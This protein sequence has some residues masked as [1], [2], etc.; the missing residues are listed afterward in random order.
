MHQTIPALQKPTATLL[1]D[2]DEL[3]INNIKKLLANNHS[4]NNAHVVSPQA[5]LSACDMHL[6]NLNTCGQFEPL[7]TSE[8]INKKTTVIPVSII[9]IDDCMLPHNGLEI[10]RQIKSPFVQKI[11][12]S[13]FFSNEQAIDALNQKVINYYLCKMDIQFV[14]KLAQAIEEAQRQFFFQLSSIIPDF[15]DEDNPLLEPKI[16]ELFQKIKNEYG[17][18]HY[19]A[20]PDLKQIEFF[21][22]KGTNK[23][24]MTI[25]CEEEV[26]DLLNSYHAESAPLEILSLVKSGVVLP[27]GDKDNFPDGK[28]WQHHLK[29]ANSFQGRKK[30]FYTIY[31]ANN[32]GNSSVI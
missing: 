1:V 16:A 26:N 7:T 5:L 19:Q 2:D 6:F 8:I 12:I 14:P 22:S 25:L 32:E 31:K 18:Q 17:L 24:I 28:D 9:I 4:V 15:F 27:C 23:I 3:Y 13:N 21:D 30:Y 29:S 20:S 11:L 10:L